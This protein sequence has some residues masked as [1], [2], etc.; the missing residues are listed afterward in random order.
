MYHSIIFSDGNS[1]R[2]T[3]N[4]WHLVPESRP[5]VNP[6]KKKTNYVNVPGSNGSL[7][8]SEVLTGYPV[9]EDREGSWTFYVLNGYEGWQV[10]YTS[11]MAFLHGKKIK[12]TLEDDPNYYYEG[13]LS[14][15]KW[16]SV[17]DYSKITIDYKL[18]PY[19]YWK[20]ETTF[21]MTGTDG[22][23]SNALVL[24]TQLG[25]M[26]VSPNVTTTATLDLRLKNNDLNTDYTV[27]VV[28]GSNIRIPAFILTKLHNA[29]V[30]RFYIRGAG[31]ATYKWRN[32][33]L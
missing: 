25:V 13:I 23:W 20:N 26:P 28:E 15:N 22:T 29:A 2:N 8:F 19:K 12:V 31:T 7:D 9:F 17:K 5:L 27:S 30:N 18:F 24:S 4:N 11:I 16:E 21:E 14:V 6:P 3:Y 32:G 33:E 1:N 10:I